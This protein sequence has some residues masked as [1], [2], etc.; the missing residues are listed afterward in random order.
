[1]ADSLGA[2]L[3]VVLDQLG[4]AERVAFVLHDV[5]GVP[6]DQIGVV[7]DRSPESARQLASRAR[8]RV[9]SAASAGDAA[10]PAR[11]RLVVEAFLRAARSGDFEGLLRLLHPEVVLEPDDAALRMGALRRTA[12]ARDVAALLSGGAQAA[13]LASIDGLAGF[14]WAPGGRIRGVVR[15][16]ISDGVIRRFDVIGEPDRI[17]DLDIEL[18]DG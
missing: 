17:A 15:F 13:R 6:F 1:M 11:H 5:F 10:D 14:V 16:T 9:Q 7:L 18:V 12:G 2:A 3:L 8:R 4:P